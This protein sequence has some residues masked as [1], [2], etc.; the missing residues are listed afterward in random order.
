MKSMRSAWPWL[1]LMAGTL[2]LASTPQRTT[3]VF[4]SAT[5]PANAAAI[6]AGAGGRVTLAI[7]EIGVVEAEC[8]AAALEALRGNAAV[9]A[10]SPSID[11]RLSPLRMGE[12]ENREPALDVAALAIPTNWY[13]KALQWDIA[14]VTHGWASF[15]QA[16]GSHA[17]VVGI[18]DS[19]VNV[20]HYDLRAN[21]LGGRNF[22]DDGRPADYI[23]D[24]NGHGSHIA[25]TIAGSGA[26]GIAG[27]GPNLG[28]RAY[29]V[30]DASGSAPSTRIIA[31]IVAAANDGVDV[32]SLSMGGYDWIAGYKM[33]GDP[34][35]TKDSSEHADWQANQRAAKYAVDHGV[36]MV[37]SAGNDAVDISNPSKV[38]DFLNLKYQNPPY[39]LPITFIGA[40]KRIFD[41]A[42]VIT[43]AATDENF[44]RAS[45]SNF[46]AGAITLS[47]PGGDLTSDVQPYGL[48]LSSYMASNPDS[49]APSG[50]YI[51]M[52]GT[53][54]AVPKV[55][56]TAALIIDQAKARGEKLSPAQVAVILKQTASH[57]GVGGHDKELG[58]GIVSAFS[59]VT[60]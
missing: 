55:S 29:R 45:Y 2:A 46:G 57:T 50:R 5:L 12:A 53:S 33:D 40:S 14:Q 60:R 25:G 31:G 8:S 4:K 39:N 38:T 11:F 59:A 36:V 32:I 24:W 42:G 30:S 37:V 52:V 6:V 34:G 27:V 41:V 51:F 23:R 19:G 21:I 10:A 15:F 7:P 1:C 3:V 13:Y 49:S 44:V 22:V 28:I 16:S 9:A 47:A 54:M 20:N 26:L 58:A 17:T 18:V 48:C 35:K 56:A 43:V